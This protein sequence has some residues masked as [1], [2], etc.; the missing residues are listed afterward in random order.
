MRRLTTRAVTPARRL[1]RTPRSLSRAF[2]SQIETQAK[3]PA[4]LDQ[5]TELSNGLRVATESLPGPFA[6]VG[7]YVDAGSRYENESLRGVSHI[8][9]R[10]AFKS[11][12]QRT[13]D[14]MVEAL[15][16]LGGNIQCAS[17]RESLMYQSASFNSAVPTTLA[18]LAETIR[19]PLITE[20]EV[21]QQLE[22]A[23]YEITE[24]WA[25]PEMILPE[26]VNI[27][28]YRNNTLGNPLL[29]PRERLGEINRGVVQRYRETFYKPERM[30]VAFAGVAH[31]EAVR[32]TEKYFGDMKR[33]KRGLFGPGSETTIAEEELRSLPS[34]SPSS[35]TS[36]ISANSSSIPSPPPPSTP[37]SSS[38]ANSGGLLSHIP[39]LKHISRTPTLR[40]C[41]CTCLPRS[42]SSTMRDS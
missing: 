4:E 13:A 36:T 10:L 19:D 5:V 41:T 18:L 8:I 31:E 22:V 25:K 23:D 37:T 12:S 28:A 39:F 34:L 40:P 9:D 33:G 7:V 14:Q 30:V 3:D 32:L 1:T 35:T 29:C 11:T 16:R 21:Q 38:K 42:S 20:E 15:E 26:L 17:A 24:L 2:S 6:G 27:A